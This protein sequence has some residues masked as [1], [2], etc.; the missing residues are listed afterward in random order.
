MAAGT[1]DLTGQAARADAAAPCISLS[2]I[3]KSF[4]FKN[5]IL[6]SQ[7]MIEKDVMQKMKA[8]VEA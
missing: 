3:S 2:G 7:K 6:L 5:M 8:E 1:G 4:S